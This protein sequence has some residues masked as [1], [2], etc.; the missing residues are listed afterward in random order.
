MAEEGNEA[1]KLTE[2]RCRSGGLV[3]ERGRGFGVPILGR[4]VG[5]ATHRS[6]FEGGIV[7]C[8]DKANREREREGVVESAVV[9]RRVGKRRETRI[10]GSAVDGRTWVLSG[11]TGLCGKLGALA[12]AI[13]GRRTA[14]SE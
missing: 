3:E 1:N 2:S 7:D 6:S 12:R 4:D 11:E 9:G 13:N 5:F 10:C 14:R 8:C